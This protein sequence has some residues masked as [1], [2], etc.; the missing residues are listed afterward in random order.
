MNRPVK[1]SAPVAK[2]LGTEVIGSANLC[3][4][5]QGSFNGLAFPGNRPQGDNNA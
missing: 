2:P 3:E 4:A 5:R 1:V